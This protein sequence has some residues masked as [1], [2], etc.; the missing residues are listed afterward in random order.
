MANLDR[1]EF[2]RGS[3]AAA[4]RCRCPRLGRRRSGPP[5]V[6]GARRARRTGLSVPDIGFGSSQLSGDEAVVRHALD[7]GIDY[8]DTA[9]SYTNGASEETLGRALRGVREQVTLASKVSAGA[10]IASPI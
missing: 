5:R 6:R 1:R 7:R 4:S 8:F 3:A 9:E 2:L 10:T